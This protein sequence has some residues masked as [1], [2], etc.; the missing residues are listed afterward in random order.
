LVAQPLQLA[1]LK[2]VLQL[3]VQDA[4]APLTEAAWPLHGFAVVQGT[5]VG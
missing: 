3:H 5:H 4:G 1:P 2:P